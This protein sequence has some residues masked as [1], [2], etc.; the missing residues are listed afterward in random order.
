MPKV[1]IEAAS[2]MNQG[3]NGAPKR[4]SR[5]SSGKKVLDLDTWSAGGNDAHDAHAG[6]QAHQAHQAHQ[7]HQTPAHQAHQA[8]EAHQGHQAH[9][10]H[11]AC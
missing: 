3:A 11:Q 6:H 8:Q 5:M 2:A 10:A 4:S 1:D 7:S 9:Q